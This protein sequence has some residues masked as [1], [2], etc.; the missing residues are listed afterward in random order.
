[1]ENGE[2]ETQTKQVRQQEIWAFR[3]AFA[4]GAHRR[5]IDRAHRGSNQPNSSGKCRTDDDDDFSVDAFIEREAEKRSLHEIRAIVQTL[6]EELPPEVCM[7][8]F[9]LLLLIAP[10][11]V[12][13]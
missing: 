4:K 6:L 7:Q 12:I 13:Q 8:Q 5:H 2:K 9:F 10:S 3:R 1:M 11:I